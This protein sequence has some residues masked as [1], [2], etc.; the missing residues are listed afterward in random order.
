MA[1][2][3]PHCLNENQL[4]FVKHFSLDEFSFRDILFPTNPNNLH[5][6]GGFG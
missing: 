6:Y 3:N 1:S 5:I 2:D 4:M